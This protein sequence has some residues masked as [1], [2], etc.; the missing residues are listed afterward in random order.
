LFGLPFDLSEDARR[1]REAWTQAN[2]HLVVTITG[3]C[4]R[5]GLAARG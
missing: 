2:G 5:F 1:N 4:A 3:Y